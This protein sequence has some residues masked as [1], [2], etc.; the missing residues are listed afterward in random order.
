MVFHDD[1]DVVV[2]GK[3]G[4]RAETLNAVGGFFVIGFS[5]AVGIDADRVATEELGGFDPLLVIVD[6]FLSLGI[7]AGTEVAFAVGYRSLGTF[8]RTFA[9]RCGVNPSELLGGA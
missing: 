8:S 9:E 1:V 2:L 3:A 5:F 4:E 7:G 6:G